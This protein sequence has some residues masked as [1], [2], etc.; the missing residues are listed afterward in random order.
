MTLRDHTLMLLCDGQPVAPYTL[1]VDDVDLRARAGRQGLAPSALL[2]RQIRQE[3]GRSYSIGASDQE[4]TTIASLLIDH[5]SNK[6]RPLAVT[7]LAAGAASAESERQLA[8]CTGKLQNALASLQQERGERKRERE[9]HEQELADMRTTLHSAEFMQR[10]ATEEA[11]RLREQ[12][13]GLRGVEE[14]LHD[15]QLGLDLV[16]SERDDLRD[17]VD[18]LKDGLA[19]TRAERDQLSDVVG[20][21]HQEYESLLQQAQQLQQQ[22]RFSQQQ[23]QQLDRL[24]SLA[25]QQLIRVEG[26][27]ALQLPPDLSVALKAYRNEVVHGSAAL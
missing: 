11:G 15:A 5:G 3:L 26:G 10:Q 1:R 27:L 25:F 21:L 7:R 19:E 6:T 22:I 17:R 23:S 8:D 2:A 13:R 18:R 24:C 4:L 14:R 12:I 9:R 20:K 16:T